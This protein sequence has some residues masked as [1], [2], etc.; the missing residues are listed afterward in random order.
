MLKISKEDMKIDRK[1]IFL[2]IGA[3]LVFTGGMLLINS[4]RIEPSVKSEPPEATQSGLSG[5]IDEVKKKE[6]EQQKLKEEKKRQEEETKKF[7]AAY[8]PC[9]FIPILMYHHVDD[10]SG[11]LYVKREVFAGQMA[12]LQQKGYTTVTLIDVIESL[13]LG[14]PLPPKPIVITFDD[15]YKDIYLN[16]YPI[17]RQNNQKA[18]IFLISQLLEGEDYMT[19]SQAREMAGNGLVTIGDHTLSHRALGSITDAEIKNEI[20]SAK[21]ILEENLGVKVNVFAYPYGNYNGGVERI[22]GESG[23]AAAVTTHHGLTCAKLPYELPRV[24]IGNS[25]LSAYGL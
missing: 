23:F 2:L 7:I 14:K 10:K 15:G 21:N 12:Y 8:G 1:K 3:T 17:L 18:T 22:L 19:W 16:A 25:P 13:S 24:R 4:R 6:E 5:V 20:V 9:R 11:S